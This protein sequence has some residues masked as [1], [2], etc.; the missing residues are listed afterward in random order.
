MS[1]LNGEFKYFSS[2]ALF[3]YKALLYILSPLE[4]GR[5]NHTCDVVVYSKKYIFGL[6]PCL[7]HRAP[8]FGISYLPRR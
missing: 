1:V 4:I 3:P 8:K 5:N 2:G 6:Y 7:G